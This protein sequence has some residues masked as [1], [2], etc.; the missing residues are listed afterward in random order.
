MIDFRRTKVICPKC[1]KFICT[2]EKYANA[3]G[4]YFWCARCKEEFEIEE[5][6]KKR[7]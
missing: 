2:M 5:K 6:K 3:K 7:S 1:N 4:I